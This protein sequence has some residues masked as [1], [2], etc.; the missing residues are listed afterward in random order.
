[1]TGH[2]PVIRFQCLNLGQG[3]RNV[4]ISILKASTAW[5]DGVVW[6]MLC[7][8]FEWG[9]S[10]LPGC[11]FIKTTVENDALRRFPEIPSC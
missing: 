7:L 8:G 3:F 4:L 9:L 5:K 11:R 6:T 1:M 2:R 10:D